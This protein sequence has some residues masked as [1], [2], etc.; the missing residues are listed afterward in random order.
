MHSSVIFFATLLLLPRA[1]V[2]HGHFLASNDIR[3]WD[4]ET[5]FA[6]TG[7][8]RQHHRDR[9]GKRASWA[10]GDHWQCL[11]SRSLELFPGDRSVLRFRFVLVAKGIGRVSADGATRLVPQPQHKTKRR[12]S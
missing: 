6:V 9:R 7:N 1:H 3:N 10:R 4:L 8:Y 5:L 11:A 2:E 12:K